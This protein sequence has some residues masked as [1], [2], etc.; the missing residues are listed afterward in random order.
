MGW[1]IQMG[2]SCVLTAWSGAAW[3]TFAK[4]HVLM[5]DVQGVQLCC[6]LTWLQEA[7]E[8]YASCSSAASTGASQPCTLQQAHGLPCPLPALVSL[9]LSRVTLKKHGALLAQLPGLHALV[10]H[11]VAVARR[12]KQDNFHRCDEGPNML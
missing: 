6:M 4:E 12:R 2:K 9:S 1:H 8:Q 3:R 7:I 10:L 5:Q 11:D